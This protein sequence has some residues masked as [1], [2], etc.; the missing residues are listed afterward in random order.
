MKKTLLMTGLM[1]ACLFAG[2]AQ[3][4]SRPE[5]NDFINEM[6]KQHDFNKQELTSLFDKVELRPKIIEAITRPAEGKAWFEYRPIFV[7]PES[8]EGGLDFW[9]EHADILERAERTYGVPPEIITAIIGVETRYGQ[10]TGSY[11][12]LD[13]LST[14]AF[15][16]PKRADFFRGE[17]E[18][19]LILTREENIDPLSIKGSYAGAMGYPQFIPSSYRNFAVDFDND[20]R[21][22]L[23]GNITDVIGS[24]AHYFSEH[25]WQPGATIAVPAKVSGDKYT[26]LLG[27]LKP[28][29]SMHNLK[30]RGVSIAA[31]VPNDQLGA[32]LEFETETGME[33]WVGLQNFYTITR[34]NHSKLYAMAVYQLS[35]E[36]HARHDAAHKVTRDKK[37]L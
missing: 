19:Y 21:R 17:L 22:D 28:E 23:L 20:G 6:V 25:G 24:V 16:Y 18:Q 11:R 26:A 30:Q 10:N 31:N 29:L 35:N 1:T 3:A 15:D 33:Y 36:I 8:I 5:L 27:Q 4:F 14:L 34:Y 9:S 32:L 13:A 37:K 7:T 2:T 12:V